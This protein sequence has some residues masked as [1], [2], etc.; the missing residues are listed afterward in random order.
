[1]SQD[2]HLVEA[3]LCVCVARKST[4]HDVTS[5]GGSGMPI[6]GVWL[7][8]LGYCCGIMLCS[9]LRGLKGIRQRAPRAGCFHPR[10]RRHIRQRE[11]AHNEKG[12]YIFHRIPPTFDSFSL[13]LLS[14]IPRSV[15]SPA[16]LTNVALRFLRCTRSC[17]H[18]FGIRDLTRLPL[19]LSEGPRRQSRR[20]AR[21]VSYLYPS[22]SHLYATP[23]FSNIPDVRWHR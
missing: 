13:F 21:I 7:V 9:Q 18:I 11:M 2:C 23:D 1:M 5:F 22:N 16:W 17:F 20:L 4:I 12:C 15:P 3:R 6:S 19:W 10:L 8:Q 14:P